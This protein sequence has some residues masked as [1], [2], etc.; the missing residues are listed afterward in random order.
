MAS[1]NQ[2]R[3]ALLEKADT[4]GQS[5]KTSLSKEAYHTSFAL[6]FNSPG[7]ATYKD[8]IIPQLSTLLTPLLQAYAHISVL[9]IG[10]GPKSVLGYLPD[11]QRAKINKYTAIEPDVLYADRLDPWL[12][13][14]SEGSP[15]PCQKAKPIIHRELFQSY[16]T[17][18][19]DDKFD[20]VLFCHSLY[21]MKPKRKAI[22]DALGFLDEQRDGGM[23]IVFHRDDALDL[24]D[25]VCQRRA[26]FPTG[27][28][29][30]DDSDN[31]L[32]CFAAFV[33]GHTIQEKGTGLREE[34]RKICREL[35]R[36]EVDE[37]KPNQYHL[38]FSTPELMLAFTKHATMLP[39]LTAHI[40]AVTKSSDGE[41]RTVKNP[42]ARLRRPAA[43]LRPTNILQ[44]QQCAQWAVKH[45]LGLTVVSG[46]HGGHCLQSHVVAVDMR[47]FDQI[48]IVHEHNSL[49]TVVVA[50]TGCTNGEIIRSTMEEAGI[51][52]PLGSRPSVGAGLW[53]QGGIGHLAR[54]HGLAS[55]AIIG[56]VIVSVEPGQPGQILCVGEVPSGYQPSG[57]VRPDNEEDLL[58]AIKGCGTNF[59]IV[60]SVT[61]KAFPAAKYV[62]RN[63]VIPLGDSQEEA[64]EKLGEF[65]KLADKLPRTWSADAFI[66]WNDHQLQLG[67]TL[68]QV[69]S[70]GT[71]MSEEASNTLKSIQGN[72]LTRSGLCHPT[73]LDGVGVFNAEMYISTMHGGHRGGKTSAF[74][75]CVF[76]SNVA[77][78][79]V[80]NALLV[81]MK[82]RPSPF[83]YLHLLHGGGA[84]T[85]IP[86]HVTAF[87]CRNWAFAC[88][89]TGVWAREEDG[90]Q[91]HHD[92][93]R[94]VYN[95][96]ETLLAFESKTVHGVYAADLGADPRDALLAT[97]AFGPNCAR[98][99]CI[100]AAADPMNVLAYACPLPSPPVTAP[101]LIVLVTGPHGAGKDYCARI[102]TGLLREAGHAVE[103]VSISEATKR[104]Y[105]AKTPGVDLGRLLSG[106]RAYKE[107]HRAAVSSFFQNQVRDRPS[108]PEEHFM[109]VV[110]QAGEAG[111]EVLI[112]TGMRD[113]APAATFSPLVPSSK[114]LDIYLEACPALLRARRGFDTHED[115]SEKPI[116]LS[117]SV[118]TEATRLRDQVLGYMPS[119]RFPNHLDGEQKVSEFTYQY[120]LP[121]LHTDLTRLSRMV[122][123]VPGFPQP[124]IEFRH[125]L[126]IV[127]QPGGLTLC[128]SLLQQQLIWGDKKFDAFVACETGG[129]VFAAPLALCNN[130]PL[131]LVREA[132]K[133]PPPTTR[134]VEKSASHI[135]APATT[136]DGLPSKK[137]E[138]NEGVI[139]SR[140]GM[141]LVVDDVLA[142]GRTLIAVMKLLVDQVGLKPEDI[143]VLVVVEFPAHRGRELLSREGFG[144]V[145]VESLL[146]FGGL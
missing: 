99:A 56:A 143:R 8:F 23:V 119:I 130:V 37:G 125:V 91:I 121:W 54:L 55:D 133:L 126:D 24:G 15:F 106:D 145:H 75:R 28:I 100:K 34:W 144:M 109:S 30:A 61:F 115:R 39:E 81:A 33:A 85:D 73:T 50:G 80:V 104:E 32:D 58:W 26:S 20:I 146:V 107:Q 44:V 123:S 3:R 114:V 72:C 48:N 46:S 83:C 5:P 10:P 138:M 111:V 59:G 45:G 31:A 47:A 4:V 38:I 43:I 52:I 69:S 97:R 13:S 19:Q 35:G 102:W 6:F 101:R 64:D 120:L 9:E 41:M 135:S 49:G 36:R 93:V 88:V 96:T 137:M 90:R 131:W 141:V 84:V 86:S 92:A 71:T 134:S 112:I 57:A 62:V 79:S 16:A 82:S 110:C 94:W 14:S 122:R 65:D 63:W 25:L 2:L 18:R 128:T 17:T 60:V 116:V 74:K 108:L 29:H 66:Y 124:G 136:T 21:G 142:S 98:L 42:E 78:P 103:N 67:I 127:Q 11:H 117:N 27:T 118:E 95:V 132:G 7:W 89:I 77:Q 113:E 51:T 68:F 139:C 140:N 76:L 53:L 129:F 12:C 1:L 70:S 22:E 87:G 105:A 40:N